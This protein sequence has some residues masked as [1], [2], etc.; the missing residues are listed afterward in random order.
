[1]KNPNIPLDAEQYGDVHIHTCYTDGQNTVREYCDQ[2]RRN[3]LQVII[4]SEHVR[5]KLEY[6]YASFLAD[7]ELARKEYRDLTI[8]SGCE[9]KVIDM[10]GTLDAPKEILD[11]CQ[12]ITGVF[13]SFEF[14]DK[15]NYLQA[16]RKML[17]NSEVDIWGHPTLF[18]QRHGIMLEENEI[19][20]LVDTCVSR[21]ILIERNLKYSSPDAS[22]VRLA[23]GR[24]A[25]FVF[26][27][28]AHRTKELLTSQELRRE[29]NWISTAS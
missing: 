3:R 18:S 22:F 17:E 9:A 13:H 11:C 15:K 19:T 21:G 2:A 4:F 6:D 25:R 1:M 28:D 10:D 23:L 27:S 5:R 20:G 24:G 16:L 29:L 7:I 12:V 8:L 14:S 26:G